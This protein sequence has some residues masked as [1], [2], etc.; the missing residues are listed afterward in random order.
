MEGG[1]NRCKGDDE[2]PKEKCPPGELIP[3]GSSSCTSCGNER[4][5][6][7]GVCMESCPVH[8]VKFGNTC[9]QCPPGSLSFLG[10]NCLKS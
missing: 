2:Y 8:L 10:N 6:S 4:V 1:L 9:V 3:S 7:E 5:R